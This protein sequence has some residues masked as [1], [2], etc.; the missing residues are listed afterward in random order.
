MAT[1]PSVNMFARWIPC[2]RIYASWCFRHKVDCPGGAAPTPRSVDPGPIEI[3]RRRLVPLRWVRESESRDEPV[4]GV[5][6]EGAVLPIRS[7]GTD[8]R[9]QPAHTWEH[10]RETKRRAA[11]TEL[12][13]S[14]RKIISMGD[15]THGCTPR[16]VSGIAG[17]AGAA[18]AE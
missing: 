15:W 4:R 9:R 14:N 1:V 17:V 3:L 10:V 2:A 6:G 11:V 16:A 12:R 18:D 8:Q 7:Y 5:G 13:I